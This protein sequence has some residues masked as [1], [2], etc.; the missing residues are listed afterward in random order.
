M[1][2]SK[3]H[4]REWLFR[5]RARLVRTCNDE[6]LMRIHV[7]GWLRLIGSLK[8]QV[9]FAKEP[10]KRDD[11]L[12]K[13]RIIL[14]SPLIV[15]TP[16]DYTMNASFIYLMCLIIH[17]NKRVYVDMQSCALACGE[18]GGW[19]RDPFSRNLMSPTPR[20]KWYL[21]TGRRFH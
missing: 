9:S 15:A 13:R 19:G 2:L 6:C 21:T 5:C 3:T 10:Y 1:R 20:R 16:Y 14:R 11:I 4:S 17:D 8:L 18:V 7:M 12:Q